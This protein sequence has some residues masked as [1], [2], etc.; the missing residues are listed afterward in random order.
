[1]KT[2][3]L[4]LL[5]GAALLSLTTGCKK[6]EEKPAVQDKAPTMSADQYRNTYAPVGAA[7]GGAQGG[8]APR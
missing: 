4:S 5:L 7:G 8:Q 3:T 1:M 6:E 2:M